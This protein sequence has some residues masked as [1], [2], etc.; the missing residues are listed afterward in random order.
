MCALIHV[1]EAGFHSVAQVNLEF[2]T[3]CFLFPSAVITIIYH[4]A[5]LS[6]VIRLFLR[7][8]PIAPRP[9]SLA[10]YVDEEDLEPLVLLSCTFQ[11]LRLQ[12]RTT[13]PC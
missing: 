1:F 9:A 6:L 11:V 8:G 12:L 4:H 10:Y 3:P 2:L 7:Q 13:T 5:Q